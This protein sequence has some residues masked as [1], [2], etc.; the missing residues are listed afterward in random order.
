MPTLDWIGN[1][2]IIK[3]YLQVPYHFIRREREILALGGTA[4]DQCRNCRAAVYQP[5]NGVEPCA[6]H[7]HPAAGGRPHAGDNASTRGEVEEGDDE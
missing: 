4:L 1:S 3:H 7:F 6:E 2:A 5:K